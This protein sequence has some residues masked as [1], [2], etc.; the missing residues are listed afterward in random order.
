LTETIEQLQNTLFRRSEECDR[1]REQIKLQSNELIEHQKLTKDIQ[2]Q[3]T[4]LQS[5][6]IP[7]E[8]EL[9]KLKQENEYLAKELS[10]YQ[11]EVSTKEN[12]E[13]AL[14][15]ENSD[16]IR[17]LEND[18]ES[19]KHKLEESKSKLEIYQVLSFFWL[20]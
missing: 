18:I 12:A 14:R 1:L 17:G 13:R 15:K 11:T 16:K 10:F 19:L 4:D 5:Q 9:N 2:I 6:V 3:F 8:F 20:I 7:K